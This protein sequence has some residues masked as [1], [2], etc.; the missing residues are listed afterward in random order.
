VDS[1]GQT[2]LEN[3]KEYLLNT[4]Q[5]TF[6]VGQDK[7]ERLYEELIECTRHKNMVLIKLYFILLV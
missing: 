5:C 3:M 7:A 6:E 2:V 1:G 4:I